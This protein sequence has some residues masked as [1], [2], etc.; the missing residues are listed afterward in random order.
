MNQKELMNL[1]HLDRPKGRVK[2]VIDTDA[3]NEIDDQYAIAYALNSNEKLDIAALYAAPFYATPFFPPVNGVERAANPLAGMEKSYEEILNIL[4][5]MDRND[6][7]AK[8]F[9]GSSRFMN[10]PDDIVDSDAARDLVHRAMCMPQNERLYVAAIGAITNVASAIRMEPAIIDKM[11]VIW[12]GG[13]APYW[14]HNRAF[15]CMQDPASARIVFDS[16]VPL[17]SIPALGVASHLQASGA[18]LRE[19][20]IGKNKLCDYLYVQTA[21]WA[22][23]KRGTRNWAKTLWDVSVIAWLA[24]SDDCMYGHLVHSPIMTSELTF[25]FDSSRH[26]INQIQFISR[27]N[28]LDDLFP[29]LAR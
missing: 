10:A 9:K 21:A 29:K 26:L 1:L 14:H 8:V 4:D 17:V 23:G 3:Y 12:L 18:E 25:S 2:V 15:N 16:G 28:I 6:M 13:H 20:L 27:D 22:K 11:V 7:K 5:L 19:N 24:G